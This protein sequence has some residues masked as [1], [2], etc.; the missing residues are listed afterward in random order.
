MSLKMQ[1]WTKYL[2]IYINCWRLWWL[3]R[4]D[5]SKPDIKSSEE[6]IPGRWGLNEARYFYDCE[7][8]RVT[9]HLRNGEP[10][11]GFVIGL[12]QYGIGFEVEGAQHPAWVMK[13]AIDY[14]TRA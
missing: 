8:E 14:I 6:K 1:R 9:L 4:K 5:K 12:D 13:H 11:T 3:N 2:H 7:N 10:L